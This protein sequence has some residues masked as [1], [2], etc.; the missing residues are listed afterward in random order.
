MEIESV[1]MCVLDNVCFLGMINDRILLFSAHKSVTKTYDNVFNV[2][3]N[4]LD[5]NMVIID[6]YRF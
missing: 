2:K 1:I 5:K 3:Q 4:H 6:N